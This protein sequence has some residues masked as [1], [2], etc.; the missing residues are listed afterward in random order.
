MLGF[1][2]LGLNEVAILLLMRWEGS[3]FLG[4]GWLV[5]SGPTG[6]TTAH[7]HHAFQLVKVLEGEVAV[8]GEEDLEPIAYEAIVIPPDVVHSSSG[9]SR[10]ILVFVDPDTLAGRRLRR[11][12]SP[13]TTAEAWRRAAAPI[14]E[15]VFAAPASWAEARS[16]HDAIIDR[17]APA[18]G[19]AQ[20]LHPALLRARGWLVDHLDGDPSLAHAAE[21]IGLSEDR[22]SHLFNEQLGLGIR[23]LVLWL[24]LRRVAMELARGSSLSAAAIAAGFADGPHM[25]RTFR[26]MFGVAPSDVVGAMWFV[27]GERCLLIN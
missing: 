16:V 10:S 6:P 19:P 27:D 18:S 12:V 25:T 21:A 13:K 15:L 1:A 17:L 24:R 2:V 3:V 26:R 23:P 8:R 11:A 4:D 14:E 20:P 7:A 9:A 22:L 5:Y